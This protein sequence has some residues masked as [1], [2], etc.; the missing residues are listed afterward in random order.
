MVLFSVVILVLWLKKVF[1]M[2]CVLIRR[3]IIRMR[4]I[5]VWKKLFRLLLKISMLFVI[6]MLMIDSVKVMGLVMELCRF[7]N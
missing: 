5:S 7:V 4:K 3:V 6:M 1:I 2:F